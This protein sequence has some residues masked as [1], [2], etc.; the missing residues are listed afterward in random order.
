MCGLL[1]FA[2][3]RWYIRR[4]QRFSKSGSAKSSLVGQTLHIEG[5]RFKYDCAAPSFNYGSVGS[6]QSENSQ[7]HYERRQTQRGGA[8]SNFRGKISRPFAGGNSLGWN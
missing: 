6:R 4:K 5:T 2:V 1:L 3:S 7:N 8:D